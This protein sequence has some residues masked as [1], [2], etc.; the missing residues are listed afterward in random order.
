MPGSALARGG[1]APGPTFANCSWAVI[2]GGAGKV[3]VNPQLQPE[4]SSAQDRLR[5]LLH[6]S[7]ND[8][9]ATA[10]RDVNAV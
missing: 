6:L 2:R 1:L 10:G 8:N 3:G 5:S 4:G 7:G 9:R